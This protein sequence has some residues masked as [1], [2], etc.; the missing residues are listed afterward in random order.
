MSAWE[1]SALMVEFVKISRAPVP[2]S[3]FVELDILGQR[4]TI[5]IGLV[6]VQMSIRGKCISDAARW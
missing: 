5:H 3:V 1:F 6:R 4:K 2:P